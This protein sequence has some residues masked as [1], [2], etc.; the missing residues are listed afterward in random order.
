MNLVNKPY[1]DGIILTDSLF[2]WRS[3][4]LGAYIIANVLRQEGYNILVID[5]YSTIPMDEVKDLL[6][7]AVSKETLFV[8]YSSTLFGEVHDLNF[9]PVTFDDFV[10]LNAYVKELNPDTKVVFGG[11][12]AHDLVWHAENNLDIQQRCGVDYAVVGFAEG[13]MLDL[14]N[15]MNE[16]RS[17]KFSKKLGK[18]YVIDYDHLGTGY[19]YRHSR[20]YWED[21]D[22]VMPNE[23]LVLEISRGC[24]FKC[25]FCTFPLTGKKKNDYSYIRLEDQILHEIQDNYDRFGVDT[26]NVTSE[27]FNERTSNIEMMAR[28]RDRSKIDLNFVGFIR[29]DLVNRFPEQI[30][31]LADMN[32]NS[33]FYGFESLN[34]KSAKAIGKGALNGDDYMEMMLKMKN[35]FGDRKL[36]CFGSLIIGLPYDNH[37]TVDDSYKRLT[38]DDSPLDFLIMYGLG[39]KHAAISRSQLLDD[40]DKYGYRVTA[41]VGEKGVFNTWES[42]VWNSAECAKMAEDYNNYHYE[43]YRGRMTGFAAVGYARMG[44]KFKD[45]INMPIRTFIEENAELIHHRKQEFKDAYFTRLREVIAQDRGSK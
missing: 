36:N 1:Y 28:I 21:R 30:K 26:Y 12:H 33:Q 18:M 7:S 42:D 16:N 11:A 24:V 35:A 27:T 15:R 29:M 2:D 20:M 43:S 32:M 38:A 19:D 23:G 14:M 17:P 45:I 3:K 44:F 6:K 10:E 5:M 9:I 40:A 41:C 8:G 39:L 13:M 22:C 4:P 25:K 31:L 37:K 34:Q